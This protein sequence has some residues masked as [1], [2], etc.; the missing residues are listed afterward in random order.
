[1]VSLFFAYLEG[2]MTDNAVYEYRKRR[3]ARLAARGYKTK[4][5]E[6]RTN[7]GK[8]IEPETQETGKGSG[9][10]AVDRKSVV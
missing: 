10:V 2:F 7:K 5:N 6:Y 1:M 4:L 9:G 3:E 8:K